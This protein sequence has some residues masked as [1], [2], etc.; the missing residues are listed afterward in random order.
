VCDSLL[1]LLLLLEIVCHQGYYP[2]IFYP[3]L[4]AVR[5]RFLSR[6]ES[7]YYIKQF[8]NGGTLLRRYGEDWLLFYR[9]VA[10]SCTTLLKSYPERPEFRLVEDDLRRQRAG[11]LRGS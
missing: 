1:F 3:G 4:H 5:D 9:N 2:R 6:F 10:N 8:S 7:V 11:D